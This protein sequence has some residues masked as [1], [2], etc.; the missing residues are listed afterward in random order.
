MKERPILFSAPM[1]RAILD[2]TKTQTR[3]IGKCQKDDATQLGIESCEHATKGTV[4]QATYRAYPTGG[5]ARW[6]LCECPFGIIGDRL[7][8]K[9]THARVHPVMLQSL[10]PDPKSAYWE[11]LFRATEELGKYAGRV[12]WKP[13]IFMRRE[14]SRITLEITG[15]RVER[16]NDISEEDAKAEGVTIIQAVRG[17]TAGSGGYLSAFSRLWESINGPGSWTKNPWVWAISFKPL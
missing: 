15:I 8:V 5:T 2:G 14:F 4:Y 13:S 7:W 10:D 11:T 3:R 17:I 1:V 9:E 6:A 16:L 12:H